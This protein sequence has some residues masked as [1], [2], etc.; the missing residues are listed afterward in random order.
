MT[1]SIESAQLGPLEVPEADLLHFPHGIPGFPAAH[2]FCLVQ[3]K[4]GSRFQLLQCVDDPGL[5][6]VVT[7]PMLLD[8]DYPVNSVRSEA[9]ALG[10]EADEPLAVAAIVTVPPAP[11]RPTVNLLAPLA[12]GGRSRRGVQVVLHDSPYPVRHAI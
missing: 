7:D 3:V 9:T 2:R 6:F 8:P 5:A 11:E 1:V 4:P 10:L 12:L